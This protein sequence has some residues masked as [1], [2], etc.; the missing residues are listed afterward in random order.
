MLQRADVHG[1]VSDARTLLT[2]QQ[3]IAGDCARSLLGERPDGQSQAKVWDFSAGRI[4]RFR[5]QWQITTGV[6]QPLGTVAAGQQEADRTQL[7]ESLARTCRILSRG[8][9][10]DGPDLER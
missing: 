1:P 4:A 10:L 6:D 2:E 3:R 7:Q 5:E 8:R 9:G